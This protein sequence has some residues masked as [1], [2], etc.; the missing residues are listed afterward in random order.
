MTLDQ[1]SK[2][3]GWLLV[4]LMFLLVGTY[5]IHMWIVSGPRPLPLIPIKF[6]ANLFT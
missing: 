5:L 2:I 1:R 4:F 6:L 3:V